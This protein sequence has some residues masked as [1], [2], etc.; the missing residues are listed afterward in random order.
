MIDRMLGGSGRRVSADRAL[1]EIEQTVVDAVVKLILEQA[2]RNVGSDR[3]QCEFQI[4]ARETRPQM[5]QVA[6]PNEAV[7]LL[8]FDIKIGGTSGMLNLCIPTSMIE[9]FGATFSRDS[10]RT[11]RAPARRSGS[12]CSTT[13]PACPSGHGRAEH[14]PDRPR[15]AGA[16]G[17]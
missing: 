2:H 11:R 12:A 6:A 9:A 13:W 8:V 17:R 15:A 14:Q 1:T 10:Y 5:L 4:K 3:R 7:I 16:A